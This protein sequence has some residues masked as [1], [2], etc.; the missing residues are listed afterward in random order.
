M[1]RHSLTFCWG[2]VVPS[3]VHEQYALVAEL[4]SGDTWSCQRYTD[5]HMLRWF[6]V[7]A[8]FYQQNIWWQS[9]LTIKQYIVIAFNY[10]IKPIIILMLSVC[11]YC[12]IILAEIMQIL[13]T[14]PAACK[15]LNR[16]K[17]KRIKE[18]VSTQVSLL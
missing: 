8:T 17:W 11:G 1:C 9:V 7:V 6:T 4:L 3:V 15:N 18:F 2:A 16:F 14:N 13:G 10:Y 5:V 12:S